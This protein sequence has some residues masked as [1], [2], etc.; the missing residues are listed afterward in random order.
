MKS[1]VKTPIVSL[2][3]RV[4]KADK[5]KAD[6]AA[7]VAPVA[8]VAPAAVSGPQLANPIVPLNLRARIT[9]ALVERIQVDVAATTVGDA[10]LGMPFSAYLTEAVEA[11]VMVD[12]YWEPSSP[13][14]VALSRY[15]RRI[16]GEVAA[17]LIHLV[18][19]AEHARDDSK[20]TMTLRDET[21]IARARYV[22]REVRL[23]VE[24]V[25][26][27]GVQDEKDV[28]FASLQKEHPTDPP[29]I[30]TLAAAL[31][32]YVRFG[33][34]VRDELSEIPDF[35]M[36]LLDEGD[37]L[38]DALRVRGTLGGQ[39]TTARTARDLRNAYLELI[40]VRLAKIR[41]VVRYAYRASPDIVREA[42]SAF[43]R[44]KR[45]SERKPGEEGSPDDDDALPTPSD[46]A[47]DGDE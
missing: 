36:A 38:R 41:R 12:K 35:D 19:L 18:D 31:G 7:K 11:A 4:A 39:A 9:S 28:I 2:R 44:E 21:E 3:D 23:A 46:D 1:K 13:K 27:D 8:H 5:A 47:V 40:R 14:I 22:L 17:E 6:K 24:L 33:Q 30:D 32:A 29:T 25:V 20:Q 15:A 16:G 34:K 37:L 42:T 43:L 26:D 10:D 45:R